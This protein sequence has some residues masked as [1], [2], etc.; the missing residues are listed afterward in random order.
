MLVVFHYAVY[1]ALC[2]QSLDHGFCMANLSVGKFIPVWQMKLS[3]ISL[4]QRLR[5]ITL[6]CNQSMTR[7]ESHRLPKPT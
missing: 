5:C 2:Q 3:L 1:D 4:A 7:M 6:T